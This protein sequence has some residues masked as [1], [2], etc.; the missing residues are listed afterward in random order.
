MNAGQLKS[1]LKKRAP[2]IDVAVTSADRLPFRTDFKRPAGLIVNTDPSTLPGKH[3]VCFYFPIKGPTEFF[4]SLGHRPEHYHI[5]FKN[6]LIANGPEYLN[7]TERIQEDGSPYCGAYCL[8]Y[9]VHRS[10]G[11]DYQS[12]LNRFG[13]NHT[14]NDTKVVEWLQSV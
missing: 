8:Y 13:G 9:L 4:D 5:N 14:L 11:L 10:R 3:W 2:Y 7:N 1:F 6:L 12:I